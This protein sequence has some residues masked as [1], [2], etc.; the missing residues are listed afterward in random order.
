[1][2]DSRLVLIRKLCQSLNLNVEAH[3]EYT[4]SFP[5]LFITNRP[6]AFCSR[7]KSFASDPPLESSAS[8]F[9]NRSRYVESSVIYSNRRICTGPPGK[10]PPE[11]CLFEAIKSCI[12]NERNLKSVLVQWIPQD[13]LFNIAGWLSGNVAGVLQEAGTVP[14]LITPRQLLKAG[15]SDC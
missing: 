12:I 9:K 15:Y 4:P 11:L 13:V 6:R 2:H 14:A 5:E 3:A 1:M 10:K 7:S 8:H